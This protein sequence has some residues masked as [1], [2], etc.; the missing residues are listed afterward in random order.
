MASGA[1]N[2]MR[3][4]GYALGIAG[5]GVIVQSRITSHLHAASSVHNASA[6]GRAV[7]GGQARAIIQTVPTATRPALDHVIHAAFASGLN[8]ALLISGIA[9]LLGAAITLI[10]LRPRVRPDDMRNTTPER[11]VGERVELR[12]PGVR[13]PSRL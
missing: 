3:Q 2:T 5:L 7:A 10:A 12:M 1:L 8:G 6:L 9:G 13:N 4:L 11:P